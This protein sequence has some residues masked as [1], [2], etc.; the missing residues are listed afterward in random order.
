ML[1]HPAK[2]FLSY[3]FSSVNLHGLHS[4]FTYALAKEA[5][6]D[7][8]KYAEYTTIKNYRERLLDD[9]TVVNL[10]GFGAGSRITGS[11]TRTIKTIAKNSSSDLKKAFLLFRL[12]KYFKPQQILELGTNLGVSALSMSLGCPEAELVT[13]EGDP[14]L[15]SYSKKIKDL[16]RGDL[17]IVTSSFEQFLQSK[18]STFNPDLIY[19]DGNHRFQPTLDYFEIFAHQAQPSTVLIFDDI[20]WSAEMEKAWKEI[21]ND[22]RVSVTIDLFKVGLVFFRPSLEKQDFIVRF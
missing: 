3:F 7:N 1:F 10:M 22:K 20:H 16:T 2:S 13:V 9:H 8:K 14:N 18:V 17:T 5:V 6:Y 4:P 21:R 19:I 15:A 12:A 11:N